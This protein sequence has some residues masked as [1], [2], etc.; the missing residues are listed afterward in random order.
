[1]SGERLA[2][3]ELEHRLVATEKEL[4][5]CYIRLA[6]AEGLLAE[7]TAERDEANRILDLWQSAADRRRGPLTIYPDEPPNNYGI[8]AEE[9]RAELDDMT[10][11]R[12]TAIKAIGENAQEHGRQLGSVVRERDELHAMLT[13]IST[14]VADY[15]HAPA[16]ECAA[17]G[18]EA[19]ADDL[20]EETRHCVELTAQV[21][22]L[23][24]A[25]AEINRYCFSAEA[26]Y[27]AWADVVAM[28]AREALAKTSTESRKIELKAPNLPRGSG[29]RG[30]A[31]TNTFGHTALRRAACSE[32]LIWVDG[33]QQN[34]TVCFWSPPKNS[35]ASMDDLRR[36]NPGWETAMTIVSGI[37]CGEYGLI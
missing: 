5:L 30:R 19:M 27:A 15:F 35:M 36:G 18:V 14:T 7:R 23:H 24:A 8:A 11:E 16:E 22:E 28:C 10:A 34:R 20:A 25:L 33:A 32:T 13:R 29:S 6:A 3:M 4:E 12:D 21:A 9:L 31:S 2:A 37:A 17:D 26:Q 1:M